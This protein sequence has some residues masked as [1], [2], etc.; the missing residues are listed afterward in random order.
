M[1][2]NRDQFLYHGFGML[3]LSP[4][5]ASTDTISRYRVSHEHHQ[6]LKVAHG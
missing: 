5:D 2:R 4:Q 6:S 3:L 1:G